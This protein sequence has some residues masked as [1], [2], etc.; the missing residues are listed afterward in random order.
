MCLFFCAHFQFCNVKFFFL[1]L[2]FFVT[3]ILKT[4]RI[5][6]KSNKIKK[7]QNIG[8]NIASKKKATPHPP[9]SLLPTLLH[10]YDPVSL[11]LNKSWIL[12]KWRVKTKEANSLFQKE[13]EEKM[14]VNAIFSKK[15]KES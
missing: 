15:R 9:C 8:T 4:E 13:E 3:N 6:I 1:I 12:K 14:F 7:V 11:V 10:S 5:K 2:W